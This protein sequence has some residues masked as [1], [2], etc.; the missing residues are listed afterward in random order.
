M[1][2]PFD[3]QSHYEQP[4]SA[5]KP[6]GSEP[7][8]RANDEPS[9]LW[10]TAYEHPIETGLAV[11]AAAATAAALIASR[12]KLAR[13]FAPRHQEVLVVEAAPFMGK[14][15]R[16]ALQ[17][18][19]HKVTLVAEISKLRPFSAIT[20]EGDEITLGLRRFHT[21]FVDPNHVHKAVPSYAELA[22]VFRRNN[23]RTIGTSVMDNINKNMLENGVD[24]AGT[25]PIVLAAIVGRRLNLKE[26]YRNPEQA[27][28]VFDWLKPRFNTAE[29]ETLRTR[30]N[31]VLT[32]HM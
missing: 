10:R 20:H 7:M 26:A 15:M 13:V 6:A 17:E 31:E 16:S 5:E 11:A 4:A 22:P 32:K 12:G 21:A 24:S 1:S 9:S 8:L 3:I 28:R 25:K 2:L 18:Q 29:L 19:G 14:A 27:Q 23:V 30:T